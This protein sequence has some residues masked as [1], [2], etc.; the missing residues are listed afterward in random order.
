MNIHHEYIFHEEIGRGR[1]GT[2]YRGSAGA[3]GPVVAIKQETTP[4]ILKHETQILFYLYRNGCYFIPWVYWFGCINERP[5]LV[6]TWMNQGA[7]RPT[8]PEEDLHRYWCCLV[9]ALQHIHSLQIVH[10]DIKPANCM[11]RDNQVYLVDF[12][13]ASLV[14]PQ[15]TP[16]STLVGTPRYISLY[17]HEGH[18]PTRRDDLISLGYT[19]YYLIYGDS[20][21]AAHGCAAPVAALDDPVNLALYQLKKRWR[22]RDDPADYMG[23]CYA[24]EFNQLPDYREIARAAAVFKNR[25]TN[26]K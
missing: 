16:C 25:S 7:L 12:G 15:D 10:R 4:V 13:L 23:L 8:L 19:F 18:T 22:E 26:Q 2:V 1:F 14:E 9:G 3:A 6:M 24:L 5:T 21:A 20:V 11:L 17:I